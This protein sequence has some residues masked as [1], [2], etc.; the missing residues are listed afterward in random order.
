MVERIAKASK[1]PVINTCRPLK[2]GNG[3]HQELRLIVFFSG[4]LSFTACF[5][6]LKNLTDS[7]PPSCESE[8]C[9]QF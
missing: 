3:C 1:V 8:T 9:V 2:M 4:K 7:K 5:L 6:Y